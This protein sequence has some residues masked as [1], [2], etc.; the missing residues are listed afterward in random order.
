MPT[1]DAQAE[2]VG[3]A[4]SSDDVEV[5]ASSSVPV[6]FAENPRW[7]PLPDESDSASSARL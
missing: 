5:V 4:S 1:D 7:L 6:K 3:A 2:D